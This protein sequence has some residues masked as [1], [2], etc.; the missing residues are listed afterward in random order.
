V[1][2]A[3]DHAS[4]R[5]TLRLLLDGED[6]LEVLAEA[7]DLEAVALEVA[8]HRPD[9]LVLNPHMPDGSRADPIPRPRAA[10]PGIGIVVITMYDSAMFA[11]RALAAGALGFVLKD[12]ADDEL[13]DAV[14]RA[15]RGLRY[16]SPRLRQP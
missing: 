2:V 1:V 12:S 14:R 7:N 13:S 8:A 9:V 16:T 4:L 6:D 15:A 11:E 3:D 10:F 5:R